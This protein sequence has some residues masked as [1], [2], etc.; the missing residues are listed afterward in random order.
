M[1]KEIKKCRICNSKNLKQILNLGKQP[2]AN[3]LHKKDRELKKFPLKLVSCLNCKTIQLSVSLNPKL[4]FGNYFW[5]TG[6]SRTAL[7]HSRKFFK[8]TSTY[9]EKKSQ[10]IEIASNDGTFLKPFLKKKFKVL[11]IDPAKNIASYAN[12]VGVKTLPKFFSYE[13]SNKIKKKYKNVSLI[14]ARNVI[15]HVKNIHSIVKGISNLSNNKTIT[16]IEF[17]YSKDIINELQ[18]DSIYHEHLFYFSIETISNLFYKHKLYPFDVFTSPISGGS[19]V[20]LFSKEKKN[21]SKKLKQFEKMEKIDNINSLAKWKQFA[22]KSK[23]HANK[24]KQKI[25]FDYKKN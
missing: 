18:Y 10:I 2:P 13:I 9:L 16:A 5:V 17:H 21:K 25:I 12:S 14:F 23:N 6:T 3:S 15:P 4:L 1:V 11:G 20:L 8:L 22:L 24:L 19:L 7:Q